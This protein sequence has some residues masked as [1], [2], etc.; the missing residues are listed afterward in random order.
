MKGIFVAGHLVKLPY[1]IGVLHSA[2]QTA[3]LCI[4]RYQCYLEEAAVLA[5]LFYPEIFKCVGHT[6]PEFCQN[7]IIAKVESKQKQVKHRL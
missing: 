7:F 4:G 5:S 3:L 6:N 1:A 2:L